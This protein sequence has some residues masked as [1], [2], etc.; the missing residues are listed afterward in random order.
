MFEELIVNEDLN[1]PISK[2]S[3]I[4]EIEDEGITLLD[5]ILEK[6]GEHGARIRV[7]SDA[8]PEGS[9]FVAGFDG[10]VGILR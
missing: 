2:F 5:W 1:Y 8:T 3:E 6:E 10:I 9:Q 7:V 4:L